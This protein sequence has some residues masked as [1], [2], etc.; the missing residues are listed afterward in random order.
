MPEEANYRT[1]S[2]QYAQGAI[3][4]VIL[5]NGGASVAILSQLSPLNDF[6][7]VWSISYALVAFVVGVSLGVIGWICGFLSARYVDKYL[8]NQVPSYSK[9][10]W[11]QGI[12][13]LVLFVGLG[14]F[15]FGC[16][17]LACQLMSG[18]A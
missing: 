11:W 7:P 15:L 3:R 1:I 14:A 9:A 18:Q 6:L 5:I 8:R 2:Q 4:S 10:D 13:L 16:L 12:G 17:L